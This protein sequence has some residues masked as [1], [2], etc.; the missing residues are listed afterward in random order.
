MND[1]NEGL[2]ARGLL[3]QC[4][5][6]VY[7]GKQTDHRV[8][9]EVAR[10]H[11]V[12][13]NAGRFA[14]N[15][16]PGCDGLI[17]RL[18]AASRA[19][20]AEHYLR[21]LPW[22]RGTQILPAAGFMEYEKEMLR[23][24]GAFDAAV[25]ALLDG[26]TDL[27]EQAL[28]NRGSLADRSDYPSADGVARL[29]G[30]AIRY[31]PLAGAADWRLEA[32]DLAVADAMPR[33]RE[34]FSQEVGSAVGEAASEVRRRLAE[35]LREA[36]RNLGVRKGDGGKYRDGWA[37]SLDSLLALIPGFSS[38]APDPVVDGMLDECRILVREAAAAQ[39]DAQGMGARAMAEAKVRALLVGCGGWENAAKY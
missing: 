22:V 18:G 1:S 20:R 2:R 31:S 9:G 15:L 26:W 14:G 7:A 32:S 11:A 23:V 13:G 4:T 19:V 37:S 24:R 34:Q 12:K 35:I 27:V 16:F 30:V 3:V 36:A 10:A 6:S 8:E 28:L 21:T 25:N 39:D 33:L 38:L 29:C 5:I 17:A